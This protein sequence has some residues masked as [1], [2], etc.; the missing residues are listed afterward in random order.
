M[1]SP[2]NNGFR[3]IFR[4]DKKQRCFHDF[5]EVEVPGKL[6]RQSGNADVGLSVRQSVESH[7][8]ITGL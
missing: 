8:R 1:V 3:R 7:G 2:V 6:I 5:Y 4:R